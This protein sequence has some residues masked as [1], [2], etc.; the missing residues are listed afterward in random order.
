M[1][2]VSFVPLLSGRPLSAFTPGEFKEHV[3]SLK[4]IPAKKVRKP[5]RGFNFNV[6]KKGTLVIRISRKP[7]WLSREEIDEIAAK[8]KIPAREVWIKVMAK[9]SG[10][11]VSTQAEVDRIS[12]AQ[13]GIPW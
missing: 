6:N 5:D 1:T 11:S 13:E 8:T 3:R 10:I 2:D 7:K 9:K 12:A 4:K